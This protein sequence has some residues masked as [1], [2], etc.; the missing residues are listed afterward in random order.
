MEQTRSLK[1]AFAGLRCREKVDNYNRKMGMR[2][3]IIFHVAFPSFYAFKTLKSQFFRLLF[4]LHLSW[5]LDWKEKIYYKGSY[6]FEGRIDKCSHCYPPDHSLF[7]FRRTVRTMVVERG[8]MYC[9]LV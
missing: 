3:G 7:M 1:T 2:Y 5:R 9:S 4:R 6:Y 8:Y